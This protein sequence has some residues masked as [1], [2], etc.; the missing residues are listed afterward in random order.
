[1]AHDDSLNRNQIL[2]WGWN[3]SNQLGIPVESVKAPTKLPFKN[4]IIKIA[5]RLD[6]TLALTNFYEVY[7]WGSNSYG[8]LGLGHS[9]EIIQPNLIKTLTG[10]K[11]VDIKCGFDHSV[12]ITSS[13]EI[14][15]WGANDSGQ[16]G[17]GVFWNKDMYT[18]KLLEFFMN[19]P[20]I[21]IKVGRGYNLVLT[22]SGDIFGWGFNSCGQ[23]ALGNFESVSIP[24][25]IESVKN[26]GVYKIEV[27]CHNSFFFTECGIYSCG[28]NS[29]GQLGLGHIHR[30]STPQLITALQGKKNI[31]EIHSSNLTF[32]ITDTYK[33]YYWGK[34][35]TLTPTLFEMNS[36]DTKIKI[37]ASGDRSFILAENGL[38]IWSNVPEDELTQYQKLYKKSRIIKGNNID[39]GLGHCH[40]VALITV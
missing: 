32:A 29:E 18:P 25:I 6:F 40:N 1:V 21:E 30:V 24:T 3:S 37:F 36:N 7:S 15:N 16:L 34:S 11:I 8:Q 22:K 26:K 10:K 9:D 4:K 28:R 31:T 19:I 23:L 33:L 14:Y 5:V 38:Q 27:C 35:A 2:V 13:G 20:Y 17:R 12:A 39:I